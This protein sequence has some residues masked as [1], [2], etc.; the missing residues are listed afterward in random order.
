MNLPDMH[1]GQK[2]KETATETRDG[3]STQG[4]QTSVTPQTHCL[5]GDPT[6]NPHTII[7]VR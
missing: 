2:S 4:S 1:T 7:A 5:E 6:V 3:H